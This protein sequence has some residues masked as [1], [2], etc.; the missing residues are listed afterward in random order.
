MSTVP[1]TFDHA[2]VARAA[3]ALLNAVGAPADE[4]TARTPERAAKAWAHRLRGYQ[5]DP[6][7]HLGVTFPTTAETPKARPW[8][9][10]EP[11]DANPV[12]VAGIEVHSTCA[13]HL[14]PIT[15]KA[16]VAYIPREGRVVGLSKLARV[17]DGYA[18]RLQVQEELTGQV[19][20][21]VRDRLNPRAV[22]V[23][24]TADHGCMRTRGIMQQ[25]TVTTTASTAGT[26]WEGGL[27]ALVQTEHQAAVRR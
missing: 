14:L 16:T 8:T 10:A 13:H 6:A 5:E 4:H 27:W 23:L 3:A 9:P 26:S 2:A 1:S 7:G 20:R 21:A 24:V 12:I 17:V 18:R 25:D 15:G 22:A 19:A 11:H